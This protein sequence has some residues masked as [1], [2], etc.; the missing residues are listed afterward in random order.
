MSTSSVYRLILVET[1][2]RLWRVPGCHELLASL[3]FDLSDVGQ[4]KIMLRT[5]KQ[6]HRRN[7]QFTLQALLALFGNISPLSI[8]FYYNQI[9]DTQEAPKSLT[10]DS[11]SSLESLA[12]VDNDFSH[13][14]N[15]LNVC[16]TPKSPQSKPR[17]PLFSSTIL[18]SK[19]LGG[20]F[21]S[22]VRRRGEPDGR[23]ANPSDSTKL[24]LD[25][26]NRKT[27]SRPGETEAAFTPSPPVV[28][29]S[30]NTMALS[31][32]HQT[33]IKNLYSHSDGKSDHLR[34]DSSSSASSAT[35]WDNGH[36]TVLRRQVQNHVQLPPSRGKPLVDLSLYNHLSSRMF[37]NS[38]DSELEKM[39]AKIFNTSR[40]KIA[41][42]KSRNTMSTLDRLSVRTELTPAQNVTNQGG[43]NRKPITLPSE[44]TL[45]TNE[46]LLYFS[47][48]DIDTSPQKL[49]TAEKDEVVQ[50]LGKNDGSTTIHDTILATQLRHINRELTPTISEVYHERNLGLGLAPPLSKL[51][52]NQA[53][54]A[55]PQ[56]DV[57]VLEKI[58]LGILEETDSNDDLKSQQCVRCKMEDCG[59]KGK[60]FY[61]DPASY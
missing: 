8:T 36:A 49:K 31:L 18:P 24:I 12:S 25:G 57:S 56:A 50:D 35:D 37:E 40:S 38:S 41:Y 11:S 32:A 42:R 51:L 26:K 45:P 23:T 7:I 5:G 10:I 21:T 46:R 54:N 48:N 3:G 53:Q 2:F 33:R 14:D 34:P 4:D 39:E 52:L 28:L 17:M 13:S 59:C 43:G 27:M 16:S 15:E 30:E 44:E 9:L 58:S 22:Y 19:R 1:D 55:V 20:A 29:Q 6:A 61:R 47:P 60:F